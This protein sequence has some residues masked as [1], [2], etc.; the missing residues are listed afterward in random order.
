MSLDSSPVRI[1][2]NAF[3]PLKNP[4][5][6]VVAVLIERTPLAQR[7]AR[8][9]RALGVK[10]VICNNIVEAKQSAA[11]Q[12]ISLFIYQPQSAQDPKL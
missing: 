8:T 10:V 3:Q 4:S 1:V 2:V 5:D 9:L 11:S 6:G 7:V 12:R